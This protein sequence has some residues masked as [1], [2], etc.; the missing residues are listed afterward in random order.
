MRRTWWISLRTL[1]CHEFNR[2]FRLLSS[3][4]I[5][6]FEKYDLLRKLEIRALKQFIKLGSQLLLAYLLYSSLKDESEIRISILNFEASVPAA[7]FLA[8]ASLLFVL[9]VVALCHLTAMISIKA[10]ESGKLLVPGFSVNVYSLM[11]DD[12]EDLSLGLSY[13]NNRFFKE[14]MPV[15]AFLSLGLFICIVGTLIPLLA[16]GCYLFMEQLS[17]VKFATLST[18]E[19]VSSAIG[20]TIVC[21][22]IFYFLL[23]H[24]PLPYGKNTY[25]I[26]WGF[27]A[28]IY[29]PLLHPRGQN[30][31]KGE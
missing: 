4:P 5:N 14:R 13:H 10:T 31:M 7:Y 20:I 9:A 11:K 19:L 8:F 25:A 1:Q 22:G 15:T 24:V 12:N 2:T 16:I 28:Q 6:W 17:L 29:R 3:R 27:L 30:W 18:L 26:R 21:F 23:F